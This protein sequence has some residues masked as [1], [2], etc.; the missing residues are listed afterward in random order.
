MIRSAAIPLVLASMVTLAVLGT[1]VITGQDAYTKFQVV[2][3]VEREIAEDD[4][5]AATGF[6]D[7]E[8]Q[9][10]TV[11]RDE[12]RLGLIPTPRGLLDKHLVSVVTIVLPIW[13]AVGFLAW[14]R[15]RRGAG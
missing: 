5:L 11:R 13:G 15:R 8:T 3:E 4:P 10:E 12:F 14:R 2:E 6:Y 1:W 9:V 7:G